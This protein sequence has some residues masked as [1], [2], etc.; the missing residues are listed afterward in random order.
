MEDSLST[1]PLISV[2]TPFLNVEP[3]LA[4]AVDSVLAQTFHDWELILVDDGSSDGSSDIA[5]NYA[6][7]HADQI[8]YVEHPEHTNCG[9]S[10]SRNLGFRQARGHWIANLDGDDQWLPTKLEGQVDILTRYPDVGL[11]MGA[12]RYWYSWSGRAEECDRDE[13]IA[14]G[15]PQDRVVEPPHMLKFI[16]PLA[17]GAA[18]CPSPLLVRSDVVER[19]GGWED[20]FRTAYEDQAFLVKL[21][22]ETPTYVTSMCWDLYRQRPGSCMKVDLTGPGYHEHRRRFLEWFEIYLQDRR[23]EQQ[24][25]WEMLQRAFRRYRHPILDR[26][27][28]LRR[29]IIDHVE[30]TVGNS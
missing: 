15:A 1:R 25:V 2:I 22:L 23:L 5:R 16:Y 12:S 17:W 6:A 14:V 8:R 28:Q 10:A 11:I 7:R 27:H 20:S 30:R 18:P 3:F 24:P 4:E 9:I 19:V 13:V 21:Y 26:A 29:R